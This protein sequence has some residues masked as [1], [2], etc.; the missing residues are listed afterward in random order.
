MGLFQF[1]SIV[2]LFFKER[3]TW[4]VSSSN[5]MSEPR[6]IRRKWK[7]L[8]QHGANLLIH[9]KELSWGTEKPILDHHLLQIIICKWIF[10]FDGGHD[11]T[12]TRAFFFINTAFWLKYR[13]IFLRIC[14]G[15]ALTEHNDCSDVYSMFWKLRAK[16]SSFRPN[17]CDNKTNC[18]SASRRPCYQSHVFTALFVIC[19]WL[20]DTRFST[21]PLKIS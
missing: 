3:L 19:D 17:R 8:S 21:K 1:Q 13:N 7:Q 11:L 16:L 6:S 2:E 20:C 14:F 10:H 5:V 18:F 9:F 12:K 4:L 15:F